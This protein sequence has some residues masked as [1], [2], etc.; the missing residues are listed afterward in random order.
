MPAVVVAATRS[1]VSDSEREAR[2]VVIRKK[3]LNF[4]S[5]QVTNSGR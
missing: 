3:F 2:N 1:G 4:S 5:S